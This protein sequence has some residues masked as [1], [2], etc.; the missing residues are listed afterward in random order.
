M[1]TTK[2]TTERMVLMIIKTIAM[3]EVLIKMRTI[4]KWKQNLQIL[5]LKKKQRAESPEQQVQN[6]MTLNRENQIV[7][8][9][10]QRIG[11]QSLR[12]RKIRLDF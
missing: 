2:K 5:D 12:L 3:E 7:V 10:I 1:S 11:L 9:M 4:Q 6:L 8:Q